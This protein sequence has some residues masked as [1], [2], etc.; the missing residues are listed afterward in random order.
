M[1]DPTGEGDKGVL[2]LDFDRSRIDDDAA[3]RMLGH[4]QVLL[5]SIAIQ[6]QRKLGELPILNAGERHQLLVEWNQTA[7]DYPRGACIHELFEARVE[8]TPESV[9]VAFEDQRLGAVQDLQ[10]PAFGAQ[11]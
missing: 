10:T 1:A 3:G 11:S 6:P 5:E 8:M 4:L 2:R 9:A 7:A